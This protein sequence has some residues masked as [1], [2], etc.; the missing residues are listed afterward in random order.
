MTV[1]VLW[2]R[3]SLGEL[4]CAADTRISRGGGTATDGGPK[5]LPIPV[6]CHKSEGNKKWNSFRRYN[7]GFAYAGS[8]LSAI[9]THALATACTQNLAANRGYEKPVT[10]KAVAELFQS[11]GEHYICDMSARLGV[12]DNNKSYFFD[13][14][15]FGFCP[16]ERVFKAYMLVSNIATGTFRMLLAEML[17]GPDRYHSIGSGSTAFEKLHVELEQF[18][19]N[20]GVLTTLEEMLK[21]EVQPDVGG[22]LQIGV[23]KTTGFRII[24]VLNRGDGPGKAYVS[25]LGWDTTSARMF[26]GYSVGYESCGNFQ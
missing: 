6:V 16:V 24:P 13:A 3:K 23:S 5:I 10:L 22:H 18:H 2:Y 11:V 21:R 25:F 17:I 20:P 4:W 1:V 26:E 8:T 7:F 9:S 12:S 14:L 15:V 19:H